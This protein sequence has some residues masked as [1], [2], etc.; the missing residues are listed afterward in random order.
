M[1]LYCILPRVIIKQISKDIILCSEPKNRLY[2]MTVFCRK[3]HCKIKMKYR[4]AFVLLIMLKRPCLHSLYSYMELEGVKA[5][6]QF[7]P[8][9]ILFSLVINTKLKLPWLFIL[10]WLFHETL[11]LPRKLFSNFFHSYIHYIYWNN[12]FHQD[13]YSHTIFHYKSLKL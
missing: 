12:I 1:Y 13:K 11:S 2:F 5:F 6:K 4:E 9:L 7:L 10:S 8:Q 3:C